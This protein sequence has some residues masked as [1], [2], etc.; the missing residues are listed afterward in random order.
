MKYKIRPYEEKDKNFI[1]DAWTKSVRASKAYRTVPNEVYYENM[2]LLINFHLENSRTHIAYQTLEDGKE[3]YYGFIS[4]NKDTLLFAYVKGLFRE[5][6]I[7]T[8]MF[9]ETCS[10]LSYYA[11]KTQYSKVM[12]KKSLW[13]NPFSFFKGY[14]EDVNESKES[15]I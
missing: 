8:R 7:F 13:Y 10:G 1:I 4:S 15:D 11:F 14:K 3:Q 2:T 12:Y 6:G 9:D 5:L